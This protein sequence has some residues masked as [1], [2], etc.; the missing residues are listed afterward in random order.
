ML[1]PALLALAAFAAP[2][3]LPPV[4]E[5]AA[6]P[7]FVAFRST[8]LA[9][10]KRR[11][12][13]AIIRALDDKV[14][15]DFGGGEGQSAFRESWRLNDPERSQLWEELE[16]ALKLGCAVTDGL[17][18]AP[19]L[20]AQLDPDLSE[21]VFVLAE[22]G[23]LLS[24][25]NGKAIRTLNWDLLEATGASIN[26][27][28]ILVRLPSGATGRVTGRVRTSLDYRLTMQKRSGAWHI[29]AFVAGD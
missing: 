9:A 12:V 23:A 18:I 16:N 29:T 2:A 15:V 10:T 17:A 19:S 6:D 4:D 26:A 13:D 22:P 11:D 5:C 1:G 3:T 20:S 14:V 8:L 24:D 25:E 21:E 28:F 7:S 27:D